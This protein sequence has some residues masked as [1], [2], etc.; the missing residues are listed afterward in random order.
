MFASF[1]HVLVVWRFPE[2]R[3]AVV[4]CVVRMAAYRSCRGPLDQDALGLGRLQDSAS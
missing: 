1:F 3:L 4:L 2:C